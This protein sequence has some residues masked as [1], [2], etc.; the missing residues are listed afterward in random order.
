MWQPA[1]PIRGRVLPDGERP[2]RARA[3]APSNRR[4]IP[5]NPTMREAR[6]STIDLPDLMRGRT[7]H[8]LVVVGTVGDA[9]IECVTFSEPLAFAHANIS[10]EYAVLLPTGDAMLDAFQG[11]TFVSARNSGDDVARY[12]HGCLDLVLH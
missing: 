3:K 7:E 5:D 6:E 2:P 11:R 1:L 9:Q 10:D 8:Q 4:N 12:K